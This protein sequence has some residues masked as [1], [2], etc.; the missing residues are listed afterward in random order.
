[1]DNPKKLN[2]KE[3][4]TASAQALACLNA[5]FVA[6]A[7]ARKLVSD[8]PCLRQFGAEFLVAYERHDLNAL[9]CCVNRY[10]TRTKW[11]SPERVRV[12]WLVPVP[13][14]W[15]ADAIEILGA[16]EASD[17]NEL[18]LNAQDLCFG[19]EAARYDYKR[20]MWMIDFE[21]FSEAE[22]PLTEEECGHIGQAIRGIE[23]R[24]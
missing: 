4:C 3:R 2:W 19:F 9:I 22:L 8:D 10:T 14:L 6:T 15:L 17:H 11:L 18:L 23:A 21:M 12:T 13:V 7:C 20:F 1:M 16:D 5:H 24:S